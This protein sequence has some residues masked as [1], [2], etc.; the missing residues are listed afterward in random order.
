MQLFIATFVVIT[1]MGWW[2]PGRTLATVLPLLVIPLVLTLA[3]LPGT[4]KWFVSLLGVHTALTTF[5]LAR[6][7]H[8]REIRLAVNPF[9]M[10]SPIYQGFG[11]LFPNYTAWDP[12]TWATTIGWLLAIILTMGILTILGHRQ[13]QKN[14]VLLEQIR[15]HDH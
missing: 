8:A 11:W 13:N 9:E 14:G 7:G 1:M 15:P 3:V 12:H 6:A 2:F 4:L 10:D 5:V